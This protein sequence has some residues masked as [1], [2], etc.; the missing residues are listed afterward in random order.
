MLAKRLEI[1]LDPK[2]YEL[3][4]KKAEDG[5]ISIAS[6]VRKAL[7][8]KIIEKDTRKKEQALKRLFSPA[9]ETSFDKW[10]KEKKRITKTRVKEIET[11]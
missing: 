1:L 11:H 6:L 5:G 3:L 8:E 7:K 10:A 4:R 9:M 2:D